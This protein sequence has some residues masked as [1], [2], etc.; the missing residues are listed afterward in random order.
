MAA[1]KEWQTHL[2]VAE[3]ETI[4]KTSHS[5]SWI[6]VRDRLSRLLSLVKANMYIHVHLS[7]GVV[8]WCWTFFLKVFAILFCFCVIVL[9][10]GYRPIHVPVGHAAKRC[11]V[12]NDLTQNSKFFP[13]MNS[14]FYL[15]QRSEIRICGIWDCFNHTNQRLYKIESINSVY[16]YVIKYARKYAPNY[17]NIICCIGQCLQHFEMLL[18]TTFQNFCITTI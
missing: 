16:M 2:D 15:S 9:N 4:E 1:A 3:R 8:R 18:S 5:A 17:F 13:A 14:G 11:C 10:T 12:G 6:A 7:V